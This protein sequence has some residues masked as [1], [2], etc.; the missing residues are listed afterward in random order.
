MTILLTVFI[1]RPTKDLG[2]WVYNSGL[3]P[4]YTYTSEKFRTFTR[5]GIRTTSGGL[6]N[7]YADI[8]IGNDNVSEHD[9]A[10]EGAEEHDT[11]TTTSQ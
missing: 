2:L 1:I 6:G 7:G 10:V 8:E 11:V 3:V 4:V 9:N 5:K